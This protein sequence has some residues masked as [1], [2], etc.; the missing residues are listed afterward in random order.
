MANDK[1]YIHEFIDIIGHNRASYMHHMLANWSPEGQEQRKQLCYGVWA[2]L[3]S[4]GR[5]PETVNIWEHDGWDGL[6]ASFAVET[7][8]AGAQDPALE[9]WW[10]KAAEFRRGGIDRILEPAPWTR[11]ISELCA[12]GVTGAC[13][14]HELVRVRA[15]AA[16]D[17]LEQVRERYVPVASP[18]D[19][20]LTGA[21]RTA[22]TNDDECILLWAIPTWQQWAAFEKAHTSDP[23]VRTFRSVTRDIVERWE[24][25]VL[26]DAPL[27]PFKTGRQ[28]SRE[29]RTDWKT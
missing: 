21:W 5:W 13:Y 8:G 22:M 14:A 20:V 24:R 2:V 4:T 17:F 25:I 6:A 23:D 11:T 19:W 3:G 28:P 10:A 29:D 12:A 15:G 7:V 16:T 26:V 1:I 27:S 18:Y 9:K